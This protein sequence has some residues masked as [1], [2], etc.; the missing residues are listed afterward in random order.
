MAR[1]PRFNLPGVSPARYCP[2]GYPWP[3]RHLGHAARRSAALSRTQPNPGRTRLGTDLEVRRHSCQ[4]L[5]LGREDFKE[6]LN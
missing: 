1:K 2:L 6:K 5:V 4:E 3:S